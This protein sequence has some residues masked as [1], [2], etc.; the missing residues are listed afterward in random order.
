MEEELEFTHHN[1]MLK[2]SPPDWRQNRSHYDELIEN[3]R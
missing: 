1:K 3:M 2:L